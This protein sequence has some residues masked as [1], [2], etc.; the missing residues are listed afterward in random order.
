MTKKN[1]EQIVQYTLSNAPDGIGLGG[2][3]R[4]TGR[5]ESIAGS[6]KHK[7]LQ[8]MIVVEQFDKVYDK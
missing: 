3:V 4:L 6:T 2:R 7:N 1:N 8:L 5:I